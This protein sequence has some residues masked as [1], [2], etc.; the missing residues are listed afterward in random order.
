MYTSKET[1]N[2]LIG[3]GGGDIISNKLLHKIKTEITTDE[4]MRFSQG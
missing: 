1:Q 4:A 2:K 3:I